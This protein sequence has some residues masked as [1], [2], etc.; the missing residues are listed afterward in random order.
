MD[1]RKRRA[2]PSEL[3]FKN[4]GLLSNGVGPTDVLSWGWLRQSDD[5]QYQGKH[6]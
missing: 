3:E 2:M 6:S 1:T 5:T 4:I